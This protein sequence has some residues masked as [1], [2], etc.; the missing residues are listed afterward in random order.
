[1]SLYV[2]VTILSQKNSSIVYFLHRIQKLHGFSLR[3]GHDVLGVPRRAVLVKS[4]LR[5]RAAVPRAFPRRCQQSHIVTG[6][7]G[8]REGRFLTAHALCKRD[9]AAVHPLFRIEVDIKLRRSAAEVQKNHRLFQADDAVEPYGSV[10]R[11]LQTNLRVRSIVMSITL[12]IETIP[13][14]ISP[15]QPSYQILL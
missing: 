1:M 12:S 8:I 10:I 3:Q 7:H 15:L 2:F 4:I 11:F 14:H 13:I 5:F 9:R 6:I